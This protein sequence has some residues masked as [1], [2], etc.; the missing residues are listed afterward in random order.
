MRVKAKEVLNWHPV[1]GR[2]YI[3]EGTVYTV[4]KTTPAGV[5]LI[6]DDTGEPTC[7][8]LDTCTHGV[9]WEVVDAS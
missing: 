7:I 1:D 6:A 8:R 4:L 9:I 2:S 5:H 3:T